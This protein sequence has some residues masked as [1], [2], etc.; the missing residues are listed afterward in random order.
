MAPSRFM[1]SACLVGIKC[2][3]DGKDKTDKKIKKLMQR[4]VGIAVCPETLGGLI[5]PRSAGEITRGEGEDVLLGT[6]K[7]VSRSRKDVTRQM[8]SGA[9]RTLRI[10]QK[11][12]IKSALL[13]EKSPSCGSEKICRNKKIIPGQGVTAALLKKRGVRV[14]PR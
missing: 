5:I 6:S 3:F 10:A 11:F 9:I 4:G 2:R 8:V 1:I 12:N 7:V 13:K 14:I